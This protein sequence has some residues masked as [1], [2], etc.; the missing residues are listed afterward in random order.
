MSWSF[1]IWAFKS[2]E[3]V[4]D[5]FI[6]KLNKNRCQGICVNFFVNRRFLVFPRILIS[7]FCKHNYN[8]FINLIF[9]N[10]I[11]FYHWSWLLFK[12]DIMDWSNQT[13]FSWSSRGCFRIIT[14]SVLSM[15]GHSRMIFLHW[16]SNK[17]LTRKKYL[18][19]S[20]KNKFSRCESKLIMTW[21]LVLVFLNM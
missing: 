3:V 19:I 12:T 6:K 13:W 16:E 10:F 11:A 8:N 9:T 1:I 15:N 2:V 7:L 17:M 18:S 5:S 4:I 21:F 14:V 20:L